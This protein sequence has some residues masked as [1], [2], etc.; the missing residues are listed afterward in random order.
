MAGELFVND[1]TGKKRLPYTGPIPF[2]TGRMLET[3]A[4]RYCNDKFVWFVAELEEKGKTIFT[5]YTAAGDFMYS[6]RFVKPRTADN[7]FPGA[8]VVNSLAAEGGY[9]SFFWDQSL[10]TELRAP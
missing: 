7:N 2:P 4:E 6:I 3:R 1:Q 8:M 9:V 10:R 5:K